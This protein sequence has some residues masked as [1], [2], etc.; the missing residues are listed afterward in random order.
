MNDTHGKTTAQRLALALAGACLALAAG[1]AGGGAAAETRA[2]VAAKTG[3]GKGG[4]RLKGIGRFDAPT[5]VTGA[6]GEKGV[7]VVEQ[8]GRVQRVRKGERKTFLDIRGSVLP[9]DE[10]GLLSIA[11]APDYRQSGLLYAFYVTNGGDLA[12]EEYR[13][14][15]ASRADPGSARRVL[16]VAHP[17]EPNHNGGQLQFGPHELLYIGTGDGGGAGDAPD[18]AQNTSSLLGK[19]LRINP[20]PGAGEPYSSPGSNPFVGEPGRDEIYAVGLRNPY[21]FSFD[22]RSAG[23]PYIA[24]G[25]VGQSSFE[26]I[27]YERV[28]G[29]RGANFGWNDFEAFSPFG[30][31]HAPAPNRHDRPIKAYP[32]G[33]GRCAVIGGY[34]SSSAKLASIRG[35]LVYGDFCD[36]VIRSLVPKLAGARKDRRLGVELPML[37]SFGQGPGGS[38]YA[39]SLGGRVVKLVGKR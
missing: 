18:N 35:R 34:V 15:S 32:L 20:R 2:G 31:A 39:T 10:Q 14:A 23:G 11:F 33:G 19:M 25:D 29:A 21:R 4:I 7:F 3:S 28:E 13:R 1:I 30:G 12:I 9:G 6:P 37:S 17:G 36:G 26:E 38:L 27:D 8:A 5:Y 24:I 22:R 16:T